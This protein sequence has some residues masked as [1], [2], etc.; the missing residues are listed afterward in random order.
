MVDAAEM[1]GSFMLGLMRW[2]AEK[3][4]EQVQR[5]G[6]GKISDHVDELKNI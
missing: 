3:P 6:E 2:V 1:L 5:Q 4:Q